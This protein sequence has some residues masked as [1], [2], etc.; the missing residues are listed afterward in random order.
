MIPN[1]LLK[2]RVVDRGNYK[3]A[4]RQLSLFAGYLLLFLLGYLV[5]CNLQEAE[6]AGN[7]FLQAI[8]WDHMPI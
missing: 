5:L 2:T 4:S 3:T 7:S 8:V 6:V 1:E